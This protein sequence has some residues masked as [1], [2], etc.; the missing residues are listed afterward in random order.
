MPEPPHVVIVGGG[1]AGLAAA[2]FLRRRGAR[3]TVLESHRLGHAASSSNAG[4]VC[5]AQA[6]PLPEPGLVG[7][8]LRSLVMPDAPLYFA[9]AY[10]PR[11]LSW[12]SRCAATPAITDEGPR[13]SP[14][15]AGGRSS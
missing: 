6:G 1:V 3:V 12:L 10:L 2:Y 14:A 11:M 15:S 4:W 8:G 9:P 13:L 5:P 7:Y